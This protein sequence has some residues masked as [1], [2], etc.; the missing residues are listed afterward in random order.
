[1]ISYHLH[2][3][4]GWPRQFLAFLLFYLAAVMAAASTGAGCG[5]ST[6]G[7]R[8]DIK[9]QFTTREGKLITLS[10]CLRPSRV[11]QNGPSNT[12]VKLSF[13]NLGDG[14]GKDDRVCFNIGKELYFY[15][16]A[17]IVKVCVFSHTSYS[18]LMK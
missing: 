13:L 18:P 8:E 5:D 14:E 4:L 6:A 1:V 3:Y 10:D 7:S 16:Y 15:Q 17:G 9:T 11:I 12:P 2:S